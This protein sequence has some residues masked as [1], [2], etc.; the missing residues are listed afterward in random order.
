MKYHFL[1]YPLILSLSL[2]HVEAETF[3]RFVPERQ[4]DFAFE[5]DLIAFRAYGPASRRGDEN[6][7][8]D[9]W[10]K[11]VPY[12]IINKWYLQNAEGQS[13]HKDHGEGLDNYKVGASAGCGGTGLWLNGKREPL[14]TFTKYKILEVTP[15]RSQFKLTYQCNIDGSLYG[16][17]KLITIELGKRLFQVESSFTK[18]GKPA[19]NLPI[20]IGLTLQNGQAK[21]ISNIEAGWIAT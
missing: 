6:S 2:A 4:D 12:P 7:G 18:N 19:I 21:P 10:L 17:E 14:E 16:E 15:Q 3:A 8:F 5:N 13:Y 11:R 1:I 9:A 20:C